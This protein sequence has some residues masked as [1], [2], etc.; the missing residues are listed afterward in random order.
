MAFP[1]KTGT[2]SPFCLVWDPVIAHKQT[3]SP[4]LR[5]SLMLLAL[6]LKCSLMSRTLKNVDKQQV[7]S[8][9]IVPKHL[10]CLLQIGMSETSALQYQ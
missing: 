6:Y 2:K 4:S 9:I 5:F 7:F 3:P 1:G 8:L 10:S